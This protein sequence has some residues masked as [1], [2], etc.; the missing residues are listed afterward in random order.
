MQNHYPM[1]RLRVALDWANRVIHE[2]ITTS[3]PGSAIVE[4]QHHDPDRHPSLNLSWFR[5]FIDHLHESV[6]N[7]ALKFVVRG[8]YFGPLNKPRYLAVIYGFNP[9]RTRLRSDNS[10]LFAERQQAAQ[11]AALWPYGP[12]VVRRFNVADA[13]RIAGYTQFSLCRFLS[14]EI[15]PGTGL[16]TYER[17]DSYT[18]SIVTVDPEFFFS[19]RGI[20]RDFFDRYKTDL[21]PHGKLFVGYDRAPSRRRPKAIYVDPPRYYEILLKHDAPEL[22]R[23]MRQKRSL[24]APPLDRS[25]YSYRRSPL[26]HGRMGRLKVSESALADCQV[27]ASVSR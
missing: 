22:F 26:T 14:D 24:E 19:C 20:G 3:F 4:L 13:C 16:S 17:N 1:R 2:A 25:L 6:G 9:P 10:L 8:E 15:D 7:P 21:Y 12:H 27:Q 5:K 11:V 18:G 23:A